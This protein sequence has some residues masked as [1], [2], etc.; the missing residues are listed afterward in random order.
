M[1]GSTGVVVFVYATWAAQYPELSGSIAS[2]QAQGYFNQA[3]MYLDNTP[4]SPV[5]DASAGGRRETILY[6]LTSHIAKMVATINGQA[7]GGVVGRVNSASQ[8]SVSVSSELNVPMSAAWFSQTSY[9]LMAYQA[10]A[11]YRTAL[12][13]A[14]PRTPYVMGAPGFMGWR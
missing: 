12:Y 4:C 2:G 10:L 13:V 9:G 6:M 7:P 11:P 3:C 14:A 5:T 8:G 1:S